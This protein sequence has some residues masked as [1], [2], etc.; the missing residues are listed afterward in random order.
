VFAVSADLI[1]RPT[2]RIVDA[3]QRMCA[4]LDKARH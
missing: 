1:T 3:A 2:P 4:G